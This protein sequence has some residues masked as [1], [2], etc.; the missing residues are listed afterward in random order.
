M[1][2]PGARPPTFY[3]AVKARDDETVVFSWIEWPDKAARD[4]GMKK[5]MEEMGSDMPEMPFDG[6]RMI[7]GGFQ[8]LLDGVAPRL[9]TSPWCP[10]EDSNF[11]DLSAT[12]T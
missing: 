9:S 4:E 12:G 7:F 5:V 6:K 8:A 1:T 10:G 3:G 11:H 2:C